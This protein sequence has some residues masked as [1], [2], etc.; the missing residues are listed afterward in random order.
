MRR[1]AALVTAAVLGTGLLSSVATAEHAA[2][3]ISPADQTRTGGVNSLPSF[4]LLDTRGGVGAPT[5]A[6]APG[7]TVRLQVL[8]RGGVP[9]TGVAVVV[10]NVTVTSASR[11]GFVTVFGD[12]SPRPAT[13][14]LNFIPG[15]TVA[16]LVMAPV[17]T[18]GDVALYNGSPGTVQLVADVSGFTS[19]AVLYQPGAYVAVPPIRLLDTRSG[20]G[21]VQA[22]VPAGG[23]VHL[24]VVGRGDVTNSQVS[25][26]LNVTAT[27]ATRSGFVTAFADGATRPASSNLD[28]AAEQTM[29]NLVIAPVGTDGKVALYNGSSGTV[30]ILADVAGYFISNYPVLDSGAA[31]NQLPASRVLDTRVGIGASRGALPPGGTAHV[32]VSGRGGVPAAGVSAVVLEVVATGS[33]RSGYATVYADGLSRPVASNLNFAA[34]QTVANLVIAPV[35]ADGD[36]A[37]YNGSSGSVQ[38]IADVSGWYSSTPD[39]VYATAATPNSTSIALSWTNPAS[40][41]L[42]GV[43]IRRSLGSTAPASPTSGTLVAEV[44]A[45]AVSYDD[46]NLSSATQ[47][48]YAL[49]A[50]DDAGDYAVMAGE[51]A[52]TTAAG[53]GDVSGTVTQ[54]GTNV[55]L[56]GVWVQA[57][58]SPSGGHV[59]QADVGS[60]GR[61]T[62]TGVPAGTA[63][64]VCFY[65]NL[66]YG[67]TSDSAGYNNQCWQD[68]PATTFGVA[69]A[70]TPVTVTAGATTSGIDAAISGK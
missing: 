24:Q 59:Y 42:T 8:G 9:A 18:D 23:T 3:V 20:L 41:T 13:S 40:T 66:A 37:L 29:P 28:F 38:F 55:P 49:F 22:A 48:S 10:L 36:V 65:A 47:Y 31:F 6:V 61:Y 58:T 21:A 46:T 33:T 70:P 57:N 56:S 2:A 51:E 43:T 7:G 30:Q 53:T 35:G 44:P 17:G 67:G 15:Q 63:Y 50:H 60:G 39:P 34:T 1:L 12:G 62:I 11:P 27:G 69:A 26:V 68:Q 54:A 5:A 14:N 19:T 45:A 64:Q 32:E 25:V 52:T 16:N 4:R